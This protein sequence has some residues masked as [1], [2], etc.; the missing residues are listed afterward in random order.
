[1]VRMF[2]RNLFSCFTY[3]FL[4]MLE[5]FL[6]KFTLL[7]HLYLF[8]SVKIVLV[9]STRY[10]VWSPCDEYSRGI[11]KTSIQKFYGTWKT[12]FFAIVLRYVD[13]DMWVMLVSQLCSSM[14]IDV[15]VY[16]SLC[17]H[18]KSIVMQWSYILLVVYCSV[19]V[20]FYVCMCIIMVS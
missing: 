14:N 2:W 9:I 11:M 18:V 4:R 20:M 13:D 5:F 8:E 16:D 10:D 19:L 1:V 3:I 6:K 15:K 17:K 12:W 7:L